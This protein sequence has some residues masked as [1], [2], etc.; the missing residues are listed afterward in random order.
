MKHI[1]IKARKFFQC[2][3]HG[4][5]NFLICNY[6]VCIKKKL[7]KTNVYVHRELLIKQQ[8]SYSSGK[9]FTILKRGDLKLYWEVSI[10]SL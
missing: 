3:D 4:T 7:S 9:L 1:K 5:F 2:S 10:N 6:Y 8:L